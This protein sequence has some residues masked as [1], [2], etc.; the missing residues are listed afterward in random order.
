SEGTKI[1]FVL[2]NNDQFFRSQIFQ[3]SLN[4]KRRVIAGSLGTENDLDSVEFTM[5]AQ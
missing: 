3:P 5:R 2:Y 4:I 1:G